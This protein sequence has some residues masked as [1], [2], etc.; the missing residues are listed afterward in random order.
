MG[1]NTHAWSHP[2]VIASGT[3]SAIATCILIRVEA[4]VDMPILQVKLI[5]KSPIRNILLAGFLL[6]MINHT[7]KSAPNI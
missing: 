1:G 6:N 5:S 2:A 3:T 7:V 4:R